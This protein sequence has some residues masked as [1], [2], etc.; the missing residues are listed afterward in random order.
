M[1]KRASLIPGPGEYTPTR[2]ARRGSL[3]F[4]E[5]SPKSE[6]DMAIYRSRDLPSAQDY[7]KV[8]R[9]PVRRRSLVD[10][11]AH[12]GTTIDTQIFDKNQSPQRVQRKNRE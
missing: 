9:R 6:I 4:S 7:A 2:V 8:D 1:I 5:F 3:K 12:L 10:L 11:G